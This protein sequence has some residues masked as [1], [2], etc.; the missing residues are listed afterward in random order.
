MVQWEK[1]TV[2]DVAVEKKCTTK[3]HVLGLIS[4]VIFIRNDGGE[5]KIL[6]R[7]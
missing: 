2:C 7:V 5:L 1:A 3:E 4:M 6:A